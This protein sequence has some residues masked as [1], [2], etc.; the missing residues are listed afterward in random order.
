MCFFIAQCLHME[1]LLGLLHLH[2][3]CARQKLDIVTCELITRQGKQQ[4]LSAF[5]HL[6]SCSFT[7]QPFVQR[8]TVILA[9]K[10]L[11]VWLLPGQT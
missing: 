2:H 5:G 7:P 10:H 4:V 8:C 3:R 6:R 9:T 11:V 1:L